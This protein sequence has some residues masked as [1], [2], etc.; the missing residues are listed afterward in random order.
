MIT[1]DTDLLKE[2]GHAWV[3]AEM[4][5]LMDGAMKSVRQKFPDL[6]EDLMKEAR[7]EA[8]RQLNHHSELLHARLE[9]IIDGKSK[10]E[11]AR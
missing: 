5:K 1:V 11:N 7:A 10:H 4:A 6:P 8:R 9:R 2:W 3:D